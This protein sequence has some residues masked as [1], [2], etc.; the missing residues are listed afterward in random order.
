V[1]HLTRMDRWW[2]DQPM[3]LEEFKNAL[4]AHAPRLR[5]AVS[6]DHLVARGPYELC[7]N[8]ALLDRYSV[9]IRYEPGGPMDL[10]KVWETGGRIER[11]QAF[12]INE[13]DGSCCLSVIDE[14]PALTGDHSF[15]GFL[16]GP[17]RNFFLSQTHYRLKGEWP[18][19][20]RAHGLPGLLESYSELVGCAPEA[21]AVGRLLEFL[22]IPQPKGHW[23]CPC[24]SGLPRRR[25]CREKLN[26][27]AVRIPPQMAERLLAN[28]KR[29]L[30]HSGKSA[31]AESIN[32]RHQ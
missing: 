24:G 8:G 27:I 2:F 12:H 17:F 28:L 3:R 4:K 14:W 32:Y 1:V 23:A 26:A 11:K 6:S 9:E 15:A 7:D 16:Q 20:D 29:L 5:V 10:P 30:E 18:F 25:C 19:K 13:G 22:S 21:T 31:V